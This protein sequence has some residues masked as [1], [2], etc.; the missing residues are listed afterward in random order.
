M[1][2][3]TSINDLSTSKD[4]N[5]PPGTEAPTNFDDYLRVYASYIASL[6]DVVLSGTANLTTANFAYTGTLTGSTGILN[7][8]SGQIYKTAGGDVGIGVVPAYPF[9]VSRSQNASTAARVVNGDA[10][11]SATATIRLETQGGIWELINRRSGGVVALANGGTERLVIDNVGNL[12]TI[13]SNTPPTLDVNGK[14]NLTP[15]SNTNMR[16]S[17]RGSDGVTRTGNITL[18]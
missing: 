16:I 17:Y 5:S 8:G 10:G 9:D 1:P 7:I 18:S 13:P 3:P 11:A 4:S 14:M 12:V 2:L 15:T 6:R